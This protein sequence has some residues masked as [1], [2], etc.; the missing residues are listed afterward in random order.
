M[1]LLISS[2]FWVLAKN[3][4]QSKKF[5]LKARQTPFDSRALYLMTSLRFATCHFACIILASFHSIES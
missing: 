3:N 2:F 5:Q 1:N 4:P